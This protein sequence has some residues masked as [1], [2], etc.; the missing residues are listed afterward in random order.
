[1]RFIKKQLSWWP[2][3]LFVG[4]AVF[5]MPIATRVGPDAIAVVN[6][7]QHDL[8]HQTTVHHEDAYSKH[9]EESKVVLGPGVAA[10]QD[11]YYD[12][13][14]QYWEKRI[15]RELD[16]EDGDDNDDEDAKDNN[17]GKDNDD[18]DEDVDDVDQ[19]LERRREYWR[20]RVDKG[21]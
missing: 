3:V 18:D 11:D 2:M 19:E 17:A 14:R 5:A 4:G 15:E 10:P 13:R 8:D 12:R 6:E 7:R 9:S 1:M 20:R 16:E 21:W